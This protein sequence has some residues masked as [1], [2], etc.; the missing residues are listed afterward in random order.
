MFL[1]FRFWRQEVRDVHV[2]NVGQRRYLFWKKDE[3]VCDVKIQ[4]DIEYFLNNGNRDGMSK[5]VLAYEK[6]N[7]HFDVRGNE[8]KLEV[9]EGISGSGVTDITGNTNFT[10]G[11]DDSITAILPTKATVGHIV[12]KKKMGRPKGSKNK[13]GRR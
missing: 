7:I 10:T 8:V 3:G 6:Y 9:S 13:K 12:H 2:N 11:P 4:K 1:R 5:Y